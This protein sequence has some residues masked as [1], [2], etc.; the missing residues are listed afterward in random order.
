MPT[1]ASPE[2][3]RAV[4]GCLSIEYFEG[5]G[6]MYNEVAEV[7]P[8][9]S[10]EPRSLSTT[11]RGHLE[12]ERSE[13]DFGY[14]RERS[15]THLSFALGRSS[16]APAKHPRVNGPVPTCKTKSDGRDH[17]PH[18]AQ[19][20]DEERGA[21]PDVEYKY[22]ESMCIHQLSG[23]GQADSLGSLSEYPV[24]HPRVTDTS[25]SECHNLQSGGPGAWHSG[26]YV[27][28]VCSH[29]RSRIRLPCCSIDT[30]T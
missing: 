6:G 25:E 8:P 9:T 28:S 11:R 26:F 1:R 19:A 27:R 10:D 3:A 15:S 18:H 13:G 16:S 21:L 29:L 4:G 2:G 30:K 17:Q 12:H 5:S 22:G 24:G 7:G 14:G 20:S 23:Q